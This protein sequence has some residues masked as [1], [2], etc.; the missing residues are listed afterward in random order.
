MTNKLNN[1]LKPKL[2][3][4]TSYIGTGGYNQHA[5]D[6]FRHLSK[7]IDIKIRNFTIGSSWKG[8]DDEPHN[9]EGYINDTDKK[10]LSIQSLWG[11]DKTLINF[12]IYPKYKKEFQHN[13]NIILNE[14]DHHYFYDNYVGPKIGYNVW[15]STLQPK[16]FFD[17]WKEFDQ[18]WVPSQWQA[19]CTVKQ[20]ISRDKVKVVPEGVDVDVFYPEDVKLLDEYNDNKFK[21]LLFGRWDYRKSTKEIIETFLNTFSPD[22]DVEIVVSI[23]NLYSGDGIKSTEERL[24]HFK[25]NDK[26]VKIKHF[27]SR[28]DYISYLKTG[29]VFLSCARSEGW[30]LPLIEAMACGTPSIYT[31]CS[32]QMEFAEGKGLGVKILSEKPA[33][34]ASYNHFNSTTGNYY[35]PDFEDLARVMRDAFENYKDHKI[36]ALEDA[37]IIHRD[38]NWDRVAEIGKDT[39]VDFLKN[40]KEPKDENNIIVTYSNGPKVEI[41]GDLNREYLIEFID[42]SCNCK[43]HTATIKNNEWTACGRKW[44]TNWVIKVDGVIIDKFDLNDKRVYIEHHSSSIGDTIAFAPY[45]I[46]FAKINKCKVILSTFHNDWFE[47]ID[48]YKNIEF[49]NPGSNVECY[50][51]YH[52]GWFKNYDDNNWDRKDMNPIAVNLIPLQQTATDVLGIE[53]NELNYGVNLGKNKKPYHKKYVVFGPQATSGCKEWV[54]DSWCKLASKFVN[55]GYKVFICS[56]NPLNIPNTTN[57]NGSLEKTATYLKYADVFVGLGSGLSWLNWALGKHTYM[58]NGFAKEGHEFTSNLTKITNDLCIKCWN[59]PVYTFDSGDWDWCPVYK[60]TT[61]QHICQKSITSDQVFNIIKDKL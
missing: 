28:E 27:P 39:L 25:I 12:P 51:A 40:Y 49:I 31:E 24:K 20:G 19:D 56:I 7:L 52:L 11:K 15:E 1:K 54:Y 17:K 45:A 22:E 9:G 38:F 36:Q 37:K 47:N 2:L 13:I 4:H 58:I 10:L 8:L 6:F 5:R 23:D 16:H 29:H 46:E 33:A 43:I 30:N 41:K 3:V 26:R 32:G 34:D 60:G 59:D 18:L 14:S 57:I 61:M 53:Y 48:E 50:V 44:F 55:K 42:K 21:F 35:E